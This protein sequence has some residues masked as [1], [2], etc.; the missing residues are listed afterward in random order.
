MVFLGFTLFMDDLYPGSLCAVST[1]G[2]TNSINSRL[3]QIT[4][5]AAGKQPQDHHG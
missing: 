4:R 5:P 1:Q 2:T 3:A